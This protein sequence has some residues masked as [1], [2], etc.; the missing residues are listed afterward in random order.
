MEIRKWHVYL[1]DLNPRFGTEAGKL[2]PVVVIQT[3][4]LNR[5]RHPSTLVCP[6]TSRVRPPGET[7]PLRVPLKVGEASLKSL[8]DIMVDQIRTIDNVRFK[9]HLGELKEES[10]QNL[11]R[12]IKIVL[13]I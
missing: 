11:K 5:E 6:V 8:S 7:F 10:A 3:E 2:R 12:Q 1:A 4:F 13:D 9:K